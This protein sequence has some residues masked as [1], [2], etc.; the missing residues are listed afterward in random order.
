MKA[1]NIALLAA[2]VMVIAATGIG[3]AFA[4]SWS[5]NDYS[6]MK[7]ANSFDQPSS[8]GTSSKPSVTGV[9]Y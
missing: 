9:V 8:I 1:K 4:Y 7:A 5:G 2:A 6:L 3:N